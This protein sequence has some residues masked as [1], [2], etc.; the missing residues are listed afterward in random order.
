MLALGY[1]LSTLLDLVDKQNP[2]INQYLKASSYGP[3]DELDFQEFKFKFA[4]GVEGY[5]DREPRHD[6]RYIKWMARVYYFDS[7]EEANK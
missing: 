6:P 4:V 3:N 2:T 1:G 7:A 5:L